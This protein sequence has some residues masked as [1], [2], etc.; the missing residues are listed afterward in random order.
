MECA[1]FDAWLSEA[2]DAE[3]GEVGE[4][5]LSSTGSTTQKANFEAH[6]RICP[7]CGPLFAE[8]QS[9]REWLRSLEIVEPP[10][11]LVHN[12]LAATS[13]VLSSRTARADGRSTPFWER[14]VGLVFHSGSGL[15]TPAPVRHVVRDDLLFVLAG[16]ERG[17]RETEGRG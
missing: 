1:E 15:C 17:G 9:G 6:R 10:A 4:G 7:T 2:I 11:Y 16:L 14:G 3:L 12:I 5:Q 8:V 13:G